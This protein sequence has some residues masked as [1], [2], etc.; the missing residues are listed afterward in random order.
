VVIIDGMTRARTLGVPEGLRPRRLD[1]VL[2]VT[3]AAM[4]ILTILLVADPSYPVVRWDRTMDAAITSISALAA[5]ALALLTMPR[6]RESGR[7]SL[8][9]QASA[10]ALLATYSAI[11]AAVN[12]L[13]W[14]SALGLSRMNAEQYPQYVAEVTRLVVGVLF[15]GAGVAAVRRLRV[16]TGRARWRLALPTIVIVLGAVVLYPLAGL[17]PPLIDESGMSVL[18]G[19]SPIDE[20]VPG[21][22][23]LAIAGVAAT[24]VLVATAAILFR[25]AYV[26]EGTVSDAFLAVALVIVAFGE[27]QNA[28][29]P[30]VYTG[31]VT[32]ADFVFLI[33]FGAV[34]LGIVSEQRSDLR[35]LRN[36]YAALDRLRVTEAERATLE[37]RA[38]LGREIHDGLAQHLWFAKLK[39]ERLAGSVPEEEKP[40]AAEVG[41]ALDAAIVEARQALVT[42]RTS[43]DSDLPLSDMLRRTVDDFGQRSGVQVEFWPEAG[44]P[45]AIPPRQQIELLRV[46]Q[47]A[48]TNVR[49]HADATV[50]RVRAELDGRDL[51]VTVSDNGK[52]FD[53]QTAS[54]RG[55]GLLGMEERARLMGGAL[56]IASEAQGGTRVTL[57]LPLITADWVPSGP[58]GAS[59]LEPRPAQTAGVESATIVSRPAQ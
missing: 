40:L 51:R 5:G 20:H 25:F 35:A 39:F 49:K 52:G 10:F 1:I 15:L 26:A 47:E 13:R 9:L 42:M 32:A 53:P 58:E 22:T 28:F 23:P 56:E 34:L 31:L 30:T 46:V 57:V 37:E 19:L 36:A 29:Y 8:L 54:D 45:S 38:R 24:V 33:A 55:L 6:F 50:V 21:I 44:I 7:L 4:A 59:P 3:T 12:L 18:L 27:L 41:Q 2:V 17:L 14:D 48:L 43:L 16:A 11:G